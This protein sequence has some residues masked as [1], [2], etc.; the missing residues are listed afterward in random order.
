MSVFD[1]TGSASPRIAEILTKF[2]PDFETG[3][4]PGQR[5]SRGCRMVG[6][7]ALRLSLGSNFDLG[8]ETR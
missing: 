2:V 8:L 1:V 5:W 6:G 7:W 4:N 3:L